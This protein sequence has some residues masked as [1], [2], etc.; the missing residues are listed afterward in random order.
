MEGK[1]PVVSREIFGGPN[2]LVKVPPEMEE[3]PVTGLRLVR[4]AKVSVLAWEAIANV[5]MTAEVAANME[6]RMGSIS[7]D[8]VRVVVP[9]H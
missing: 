5:A 9:E 6:R 8:C 7:P 1:T 3:V 2:K 4:P